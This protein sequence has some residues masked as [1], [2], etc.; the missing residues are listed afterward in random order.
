M[1]IVALHRRAR[2]RVWLRTH[3]VIAI[4]TLIAL[5]MLVAFEFGVRAVTPDTMEV[6]EYGNAAYGE[7]ANAVIY[8]QVITDPAQIAATYQALT[9]TPADWATHIDP[10]P[11]Y[12]LHTCPQGALSP[13]FE[14]RAHL[15]VVRF[16]WQ[17][18]PV[19]VV[20]H[21]P[22]QD[23]PYWF[24]R[25][26]NNMTEWQVSAGGVINPRPYVS[27]SVLTLFPWVDG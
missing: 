15:L 1:V 17:G 27:D 13:D 7:P 21:Y 22:I 8:Q 16:L 24:W 10:G 9:R 18:Y 11:T 6:I 23:N 19:A 25:C 12:G 5:V 3:R 20:T 2:V 4:V 26:Q 14:T